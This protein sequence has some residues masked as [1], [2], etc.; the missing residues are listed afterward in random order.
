MN[1][2]G[3]SV[4]CPVEVTGTGIIQVDGFANTIKGPGTCMCVCYTFFGSLYFDTILLLI[5]ILFISLVKNAG[6]VDRIRDQFSIKIG[7][8]GSHTIDDVNVGP[9]G[10]LYLIIVICQR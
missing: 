5:R 10:E 6:T 9:F 3:Y 1:L 2:N 7:G 4:T 8:D